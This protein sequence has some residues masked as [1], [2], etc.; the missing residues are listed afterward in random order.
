MIFFFFWESF[1]LPGSCRKQRSFERWAWRSKPRVDNGFSCRPD[2][3]YISD[4]AGTDLLLFLLSIGGWWLEQDVTEPL[5][6]CSGLSGGKLDTGG[7]VSL[8][9]SIIWSHIHFCT[10]ECELLEGLTVLLVSA[11]P[12][13]AAWL[14]GLLVED[15]EGDIWLQSWL[16]PNQ[17]FAWQK[18]YYF[19]NTLKLKFRG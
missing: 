13:F 4:G 18:L 6:W 8:E 17:G 7:S 5:G 10:S 14:V 1:S 15:L 2:E 11:F 19:L 16:S 12:V 9:K 3:V